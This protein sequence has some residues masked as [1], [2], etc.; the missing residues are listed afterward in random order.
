MSDDANASVEPSPD[1]TQANGEVG[2]QPNQSEQTTGAGAASVDSGGAGDSEGTSDAE[3]TAESERPVDPVPESGGALKDPPE[4]TDGER[5]E[6]TIRPD[7]ATVLQR[8]VEEITDPIV[9]RVEPLDAYT[10]FSTIWLFM[11]LL[12]STAIVLLLAFNLRFLI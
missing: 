3:T 7:M 2:A 12:A 10:R 4:A 8:P 9:D 11:L 6:V 5:T 1:S